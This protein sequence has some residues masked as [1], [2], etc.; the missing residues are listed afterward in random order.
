MNSSFFNSANRSH[1]FYNCK[2]KILG[3]QLKKQGLE[4]VISLTTNEK[5]SNI[6][7]LFTT[8]LCCNFKIKYA[9]I[10]AIF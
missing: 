8:S 7:R 9:E 5:T 4:L 2:P 3:L 10:R 6:K 1:C